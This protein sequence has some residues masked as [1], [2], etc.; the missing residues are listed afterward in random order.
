M[1]QGLVGE[2]VL[3]ER[4]VPRGPRPGR[5]AVQVL[6]GQQPLRQRRERDAAR[7]LGLED[8]EQPALDPPV[9][10]GV[11]RLV[12]QQRRAQRAQDG[13][14]VPGPFRRVG[15]DAR[16][17]GLA[18]PDGGVERAHGLFQ[19]GVGVEAVAVEDVHVLHPHPLQRLVEAGQQVLARAPLPVRPRPHVVPG[20]GRDDQ[21]V[22]VREE[23]LAEQ[24]PE[25]D[26]GRPVGRP[27][28]V[29]EIEVGDA[30]VEGAPQDRALG[31]QR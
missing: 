4:P 2:L 8:V 7:S 15:R 28:V 17:Q 21:L 14:G 19:R 5:D 18:R 12:D 16:V 9:E 30:E 20:L 1:S 13:G 24:P 27:V 26:L 29:R 11:R 3:G 6:G 31:A 25:V 22:P 23:V 10:H